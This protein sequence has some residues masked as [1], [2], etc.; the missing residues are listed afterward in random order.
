M[1]IGTLTTFFK[2]CTILNGSLFA[3]WTLFLMFAPDL[4]YKSQNLFFPISSEKFNIIM[5][6]FLG[7]FKLM[8][9]FFNVIPFLVLLYY[10]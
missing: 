1:D 7:A 4:V 9:L 10:C 6:I 2:Y 8:F 5:Y 3:V